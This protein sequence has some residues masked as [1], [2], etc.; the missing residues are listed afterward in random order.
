MNNNTK[1]PYVRVEYDLNYLGG[2]YSDVGTF[3]Y[4]PLMICEKLGVEQAFATF[5]KVDAAHIIHYTL[6]ELYDN[7]GNPIEA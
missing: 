1:R 3:A 6:D 5:C 2:D 7:D 4:V